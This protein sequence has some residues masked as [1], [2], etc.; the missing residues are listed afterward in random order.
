MVERLCKEQ[1]NGSAYRLVKL[2]IEGNKPAE[3]SYLYSDKG[4][5]KEIGYVTSAMWSPVVKANIALAM[6]EPKYLDGDI[7]AE[8]YYQRELRYHSKVAKCTLQDGPSGR[9]PRGQ[10]RPCFL[11][12]FVM[13]N[14]EGKVHSLYSGSEGELGK[15]L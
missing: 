10:H 4:C 15:V 7:W 9:H 11:G 6:I 1:K 3:E 12:A 8:I 14:I 2:D 5:K 13:Q